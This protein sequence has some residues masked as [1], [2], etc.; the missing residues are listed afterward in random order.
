MAFAGHLGR[1]PRP[2]Q[3]GCKEKPMQK[4]QCSYFKRI[5]RQVNSPLLSV[6][7]T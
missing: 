3:N 5:L 7:V 1:N 6:T 2:M 4:N